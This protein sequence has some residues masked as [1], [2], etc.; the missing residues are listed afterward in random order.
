MMNYSD[1]PKFLQGYILE[2]TVYILNLVP[3]KSNPNTPVELWTSRNASVQHY[4]IWRCPTYVFKGNT[5]KLDTESELYYFIGYPKITKSWLFYNPREHIVLVSTNAIFLEDDYMMDQKSNDRFDLRELFD[6]LRKPLEGS[7]NPMEDVPET[8]TLTLLDTRG[9][10]HS[11]RM[12]KE[13]LNF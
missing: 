9:P 1:L 6:T 3:T 11:R 8:T 7:S 12:I 2:I 5:R 13:R 4:R 10:R